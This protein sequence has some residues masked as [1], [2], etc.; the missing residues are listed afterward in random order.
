MITPEE[1]PYIT[2]LHV[3]DCYTYKD[4]DIKLHE[5]KPFSHLILTGKNGSGK[6]TILRALKDVLFN[7][8]DINKF[9]YLISV[10]DTNY[11]ISRLAWKAILADSSKSDKEIYDLYLS[12]GESFSERTFSF[13]DQLNQVHPEFGEDPTLLAYPEKT[14]FLFTVLESKQIKNVK[15]ISVPTRDSEFS[16]KLNL[17]ESVDF[18][19]NE[20]NQYLVNKKVEQAFYQI[21]NRSSDVSA[22]D[23]LFN[24][25]FP[26][27]SKICFFESLLQQLLDVRHRVHDLLR[28]QQHMGR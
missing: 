17:P 15:H 18:F 7:I 9:F 12:M 20:F 5:Y 22:V 4:F 24:I 14:S 27:W 10:K 1:F 8:R 6:S 21:Q 11:K 16:E 28:C 19:F 26:L 2:G 25:L 3:N 13:F 23:S